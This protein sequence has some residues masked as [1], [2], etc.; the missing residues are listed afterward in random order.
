QE[1][2]LPDKT[3]LVL[4]YVDG[5]VVEDEYFSTKNVLPERYMSTDQQFNLVVLTL[6]VNEYQYGYIIFSLDAIDTLIYETLRGQISSALKS[7]TLYEQRRVAEEALDKV[8]DQLEISN[9]KFHEL[10]IRD[11]LTGLYNRRGFYQ[12]VDKFLETNILKDKSYFIL[13]GDIDGLKSIND[14]FG[15]R[16]GD[17][18]IYTTAAILKNN[19]NEDDIIARMSGDEFTI[20]ITRGFTE[21]K[22]KKL[23]ATLEHAFDE[24]NSVAK[25]PY[26]VAITIGYAAFSP[27]LPD[28]IDDMIKVAD[29]NLYIEKA[30]KRSGIVKE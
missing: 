13:F 28:S 23:L 1:M 20:V 3:R 25:K 27:D 29:N 6:F 11:E 18:T 17:Y 30:K 8:V 24:H 21:G 16:E 9:A 26:K 15:H 22:L 5:V 10:S 14:A 12:Q 7:E 19:F 4:G 2:I